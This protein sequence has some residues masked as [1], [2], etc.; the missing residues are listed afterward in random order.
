MD[1]H[2]SGHGVDA[3]QDGT[4]VF[5]DDRAVESEFLRAAAEPPPYDALL[6]SVIVVVRLLLFVV[7]LGLRRTQRSFGH[8]QHQS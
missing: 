5:T 4:E 2:F 8:Y 3:A 7:G 6:L 1:K